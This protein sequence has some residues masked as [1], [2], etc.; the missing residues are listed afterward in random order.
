[1]E[2]NQP[3]RRAI[4]RMLRE[5]EQKELLDRLP[6]SVETLKEL[7]LH[8]EDEI[9]G[10]GRACDHSTAMAEAWMSARGIDA[11]PLLAW[12]GEVGGHC[13]CEIVLNVPANYL[14][15]HLFD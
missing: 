8:L 3:D 4:K 12:L 10:A 6:V 9:E 11:P 14:L 15:A 7:V 5:K 2:M 13:D 1:M